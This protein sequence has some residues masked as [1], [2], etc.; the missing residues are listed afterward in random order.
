[1][2]QSLQRICSLIK[3]PPQFSWKDKQDAQLKRI[4]AQIITM[5]KAGRGQLVIK[6]KTQQLRLEK[7]KAD[8]V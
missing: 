3:Q 8:G 2:V 5:N 7:I 1:M 4:K 6:L